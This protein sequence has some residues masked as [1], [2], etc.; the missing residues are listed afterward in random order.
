MKKYVIVG[1]IVLVGAAILIV[2]LLNRGGKETPVTEVSPVVFAFQENLAAVGDEV[3][4]IEVEVREPLLNLAVFYDDSLLQS[5]EKPQ[6]NVTFSLDAGEQ[7]VG[8]RPLKLLAT[9]SDGSEFVD[10]RFVRVLSEI[11]PRRKMAKIVNRYPHNNGSFTQGLAFY[12]GA[13]Y[14]GTG[15]PGNQGN[16]LVAEVEISSGKHLRKMGLDVGFFGEGITAL[17]DQLFQLTYRNGKCYTYNL[18]SELELVKEFNY[19]GEGWGLCNDGQQLIMSNGT[20][21]ITFRDPNTF[22]IL[23]TI[24][25]YNHRGPVV[26]LNELEYIDGKI[27]ANIWMANTVVVIDPTS[28]K[29]LEEIDGTE[30]VRQGQGRGEVMNGIAYNPET[31]KTYMTGKYWDALFEVVFVEPGA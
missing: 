10:Q 3:V 26:N 27:Y 18:L 1:L 14:E 8:T 25:V 5:W 2:P 19:Q 31:G 16:T 24:E 20:E 7:G 6:T 12:K 21:R 30:L 15:D 13:L 22:S 4:N 29:V 9:L 17:N 28:G 11:I 23:R